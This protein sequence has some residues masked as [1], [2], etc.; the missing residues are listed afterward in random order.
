MNSDRRTSRAII[1]VCGD[2][3]SG[4]MSN[5]DWEAMASVVLSQSSPT[6]SERMAEMAVLDKRPKRYWES[7]M[8]QIGKRRQ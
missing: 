3:T 4:T 7:P 5:D 1:I 6:I 8:G 2:T